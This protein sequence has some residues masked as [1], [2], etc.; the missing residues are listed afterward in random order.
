MLPQSAA[1]LPLA[2]VALLLGLLGGVLDYGPADETQRTLHTPM[3]ELEELTIT[4]TIPVIVPEKLYEMGGTATGVSR[5]VP[6]G[7][8][9]APLAPAN[10]PVPPVI[11][12]LRLNSATS[13]TGSRAKFWPV[14]VP[15]KVL[16]PP[17]S[18]VNCPDTGVTTLTGVPVMP[19][20]LKMA[21]SN[22]LTTPVPVAT[23]PPEGGFVI[24][25]PIVQEKATLLARATVAEPMHSKATA[26]AAKMV[27]GMS[28]ISSAR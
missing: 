5:L 15:K 13:V 28:V 24:G 23:N 21:L 10:S 14:N 16:P 12:R 7:A 26:N 25:P 6:P 17:K 2:L 11:V 27:L 3:R 4:I 20:A 22:G 19:T 9:S 18:K 1:T 8:K